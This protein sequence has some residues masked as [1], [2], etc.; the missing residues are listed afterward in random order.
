MS[1]QAKHV[2]LPGSHCKT[3]PGSSVIEPAHPNQRI[4]V[5]V[6]LRARAPIPQSVRSQA[7]A[8]PHPQQRQY[9]TREQ[10]ASDHGASPEDIAKVTAFAHAHHLAIVATIASARRSVWLAGTVDHM[11]AAFG[12]TLE[13]CDLP[14]GGTFRS[15]KGS[16]M[17]PAD[18]QGII[19]GV[20]GL[21]NHRQAKTHFR[22]RKGVA[23]IRRAATANIQ[24]TP[25]QIARLYDFPTNLATRKA[26]EYRPRRIRPRKSGVACPT[27]PPIPIRAIRSASTARTPSLPEPA[28]SHRSGRD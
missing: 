2:P 9:L 19:V 28:R 26:P 10:L 16:I 11:N 21:D 23:G 12:V 27:S 25:L 4:E 20:F 18:L 7:T 5:T 1:T 24:F 13:K 6:R 3:V 14:E 8:A 15:C 22:L 17:I